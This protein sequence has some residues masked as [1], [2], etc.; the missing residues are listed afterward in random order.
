[1]PKPKDIV[2]RL[3]RKNISAG[4]IIG[5]ALA[6]LVGLTIVI[7][8]LQLYRDVTRGW[9]GDGTDAMISRDYLIVSKRVEGVS[10]LF[11]SSTVSTGFSP[12]D[13]D[14]ILAQSWARR[15]APFTPSRFNVNAAVEMGGRGLS[16]YMFFE[17]IP[18]DYFDIT[19][20][21]WEYTP[22]VTRE[23]P[24]VISKD[25]LALYNFGFAA[26][27]GYPQISESMVSMVPLRVSLSGNGRQQDFNARIVGFSSRLN[28]IAVPQQFMDWANQQFGSP[29]KAAELPSR[30]IIEVS[31]PGDPAINQYLD[32]H[33]WEAAGDKLQSGR[34]ARFLA[35][36]TTAVIAV[37]AIISILAFF[38]L[39]LSIYLLLQKNG[40]KLHQLMLLGYTPATV[41]SYYIRLVAAVNIGV[42]ALSCGA[43]LWAQALWAS[44]MEAIGAVLTAPWLT[45]GIALA[46][47]ALITLGNILAIRRQVARHW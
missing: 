42:L 46:I 37:G 38:I 16:T 19:P 29:D 13:I 30:L 45:L 36:V 3:L 31:S 43:M 17:S 47:M 34:A 40:P 5:Y 6:N 8:A 7:T 28:T 33:G 10:G 27:R 41:A 15:L 44:P 24:I 39:M 4:Q 32:R 25:Y 23:I 35:L 22:G 18:D 9:E 26:T 21:G 1:M 20:R 12:A 14:S 11:G 2:W